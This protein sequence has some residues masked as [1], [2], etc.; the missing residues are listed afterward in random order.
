M[1]LLGAPLRQV[2]STKLL[3]HSPAT[4]MSEI[5]EPKR[6]SCSPKCGHLMNEERQSFR[7]V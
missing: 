4:W 6:D 2:C 5:S 3:T 7:F 1:L